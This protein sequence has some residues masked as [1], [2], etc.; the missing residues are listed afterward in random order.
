MGNFSFW[1]LWAISLRLLT[2]WGFWA[3]FWWSLYDDSDKAP[4]NKICDH[5][6]VTLLHSGRVGSGVCPRSSGRHVLTRVPGGGVQQNAT[7]LASCTPKCNTAWSYV[8]LHTEMQQVAHRNATRC[9]PK[10]NRLH[11]EVAQRNATVCNSCAGR[12]SATVCNWCAGRRSATV[13]YLKCNKAWSYVTRLGIQ[14][15]SHDRH[16]LSYGVCHVTY[17]TIST[18]Q[19]WGF[20]VHKLTR[21]KTSYICYCHMTY[22]IMDSSHLFL[23]GTQKNHCCSCHMTY[24]TLWTSQ[25][26]MPDYI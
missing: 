21:P 13:C 26:E 9:T 7:R 18:R 11:T 17:V 4:T 25:Y 12:R 10:C 22:V 20:S 6:T 3:E 23:N 15:L 14:S 8:K 1:A 5:H 2:L 16:G 24:V 19:I